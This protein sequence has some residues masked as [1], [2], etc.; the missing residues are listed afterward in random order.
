MRLLAKPKTVSATSGL[1][2]KL[3]SV[4]F[5]SLPEGIQ[6][7][8]NDYSESW[9]HARYYE[10]SGFNWENRLFL[11][12]G[13]EKDARDV[14]VGQ[15]YTMLVHLMDEH[16][17]GRAVDS[18]TSELVARCD[19]EPLDMPNC[20]TGKKFM[21][22]TEEQWFSLFRKVAELE[23]RFVLPEPGFLPSYHARIGAYEEAVAAANEE[24]T[25]WTFHT[26]RVD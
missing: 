5:E 20:S 15:P 8:I 17:N 21:H 23:P 4:T 1:E 14:E 12:I 16:F 25:T 13:E 22:Y 24:R 9:P 10:I 3:I 18:H 7:E 2:P 19:N 6:A 26:E 11:F